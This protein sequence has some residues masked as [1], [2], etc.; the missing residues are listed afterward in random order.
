MAAAVAEQSSRL[1]PLSLSLLPVRL[2]D[3]VPGQELASHAAGGA[4]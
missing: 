2:T 3:A 1:P 4:R